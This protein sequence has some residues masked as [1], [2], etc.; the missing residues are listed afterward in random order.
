MEK[1]LIT[2]RY[3]KLNNLKDDNESSFNKSYEKKQLNEI[4]TDNQYFFLLGNP[5]I[6]KTTE[7]QLFAKELRNKNILVEE[8]NVKTLRSYSK[9]EDL[10]KINAPHTLLIDGLDEVKDIEDCISEIEIFTFR[11]PTVKIIISCRTNIYEKFKININKFTYGILEEL[12]DQQI[13]QII[14]N[15]LG[16]KISYATI[17]THR[18]YL[19]IPFHLE[20]FIKYYKLEKKFP[21]YPSQIWDVFIEEELEVLS[22]DKLKKRYGI[23]NNGHIKKILSRIG[24]ANEMTNEKII[25]SEHLNDIADIND[26]RVIEELSFVEIQPL[27][28]DLSFLHKNY[29]EYF[30][31]YYLSKLDIEIL[32]DLIRVN[33]QINITKPQL[34]NTIGYLLNIVQKEAFITLTDWFITN[35]PEILFL[36]EK[37]QFI[38]KTRDEIFRQYFEDIC[39]IKDQWIDQSQVISIDKIAY[40]ADIDY[41][42]KIIQSQE[43]HYRIKKSALKIIDAYENVNDDE[44]IKRFLLE[45]I[46][47]NCHLNYDALYVFRFKNYHLKYLNDFIEISKFYE[48]TTSPDICHLIKDMYSEFD[49]CDTYF[50]EI[51]HYLKRIY[52]VEQILEQDNVARFT[53]YS[54]EKILKATYQSEN[55]LRLLDLMFND[56]YNFKIESYNEKRFHENLLKK[57]IEIYKKDEDIIYRI[58]NAFIKNPLN[59]FY[60]N[61]TYISTLSQKDEVKNKIFQ[62]VILQHGLIH[63]TYILLVKLFNEENMNFFVKRYEYGIKIQ[64]YIYIQYLRNHLCAINR[65]LAIEFESKMINLGYEFSDKIVDE[66]RD[67]KLQQFHQENLEILFDKSLLINKIKNFYD[68]NNVQEINITELSELKMDWYRST[69]YHSSTN[70]IFKT[71][72]HFLSYD[73]PKI[74][75]KKLIQLIDE[76]DYLQIQFIYDLVTRNQYQFTEEHV[77]FIKKQSQLLSSLNNQKFNNILL[78]LDHKFDIYY[79][80][81]FY[82]QCIN[83][84]LPKNLDLE[85]LKNR[86]NDNDKFNERVI[87]ILNKKKDIYGVT[88]YLIAYCVENKLKDSYLLISDIYI[89]D[90]YSI[91]IYDEFKSY[92]LLL[93]HEQLDLVLKQFLNNLDH[94]GCWHSI[95][96]IIEE[97]LKQYDI[98]K[99]AIEYLELDEKKKRYISDSISVLF[100][101]NNVNA[102]PIYYKLLKEFSIQPNVDLSDDLYVHYIEKYSDIT[103]IQVIKNLFELI[104]ASENRKTFDFHKSRNVFSDLISTFSKNDNSYQQIQLIFDSLKQEY[105]EDSTVLFF[106][107]NFQIQSKNIYY[108]TQTKTYTFNQIKDII[109]PLEKQTKII[110]G[111][112]YDFKGANVSKNII[113][114]KQNTFN[115]HENSNLQEIQELIMELRDIEAFNVEWRNLFIN[116]LEELIE[117]ENN[118]QEIKKDG[119][120]K[121]LSTK[122]K[123]IGNNLDTI[124]TYFDFSDTLSDK[125]PRIIELG[126]KLKDLFL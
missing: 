23:I 105:L 42:F 102:L 50:N 88:K 101:Y 68:E 118:P 53:S 114:G 122:F 66:E 125:I 57:T 61:D 41:L 58:I 112:N 119:S 95:R 94:P 26:I 115:I 38:K 93:D 100:Y 9:L 34:H 71:I 51:L 20:L 80:D 5:G 19:S 56:K 54:F 35:Q 65:D 63:Q 28:N 29:Q 33:D 16:I 79:D 78:E 106:I 40:F 117:A 8:I 3:I 45:L 120:L 60:K 47:N 116:G 59:Y 74:H 109:I 30:A 111:D 81:E 75:S 7:F 27:T 113:G 103:H 25:T 104:Y 46:L 67:S 107:N 72:R 99:I 85:F 17:E 97:E 82:L 91:P 77:H 123:V 96:F 43:Y 39:I 87:Q 37:E 15:R 108:T 110:M 52:S 124:K 89:S 76:N 49:E 70:H 12:S 21:K 84:H 48:N 83:Q 86:I 90:I 126:D 1:E 73:K 98:I 6:G 32:L 13:Y 36:V 92:L 4:H 62:Y 10:F 44:K 55:F 22:K 31:A 24:F 14:Y 64:E 69:G 18:L 121:K 2:G 11:N